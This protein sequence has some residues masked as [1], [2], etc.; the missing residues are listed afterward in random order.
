MFEIIRA[1]ADRA[2]DRAGDRD[3]EGEGVL[4]GGDR[5]LDP[6]LD[7]DGLDVFTPRADTGERDLDLCCDFM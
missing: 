6:D 1:G 7:L 4:D 5:D 2:G 3:L